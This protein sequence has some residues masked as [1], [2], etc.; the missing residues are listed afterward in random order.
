MAR[1]RNSSTLRTPFAIGNI[2]HY[3]IRHGLAIAVAATLAGISHASAQDTTPT[4]TSLLIPAAVRRAVVDRISYALSRNYVWPDTASRMADHLASQLRTGVYDGITDPQTF[5]A[6]LTRDLRAVYHDVHL[7][8][9]Y[10]PSWDDRDARNAPRTSRV[11]R[12]YGAL[13]QAKTLNFG[14]RRAEI[15]PGNIGYLAIDHLFDVG[16]AA[17]SAVESAFSVVRHGRVL[18]IDLRNNRGGSPDMVRLICNYLFPVRTHLNDLY[19]RRS[20]TTTE[21]WSEPDRHITSL[22]NV[23]V[24]VLVSRQTF[25]A[26][27]ELA[28]DL[29]S[30]HRAVIVGEATGGGAHAVWG[31]PLGYG[32]VANIPYARAINPVTKTNW[33]DIGVQPDIGV[34]VDSAL[35][36]VVKL[37]PATAVDSPRRDFPHA[38]TSRLRMPRSSIR[39]GW[40]KLR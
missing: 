27:E 34:G 18:I 23:P 16:P 6:A 37:R 40:R 8:I 35:D 1:F 26:A 30:R 21:Y 33:E 28:Y 12:R 7:S 13:S 9:A 22:F 32:F 15:L 24:F 36:L 20:G 10:A 29:Q 5:A 19:E 11:T 38:D 3:D 14:F 17:T 2:V 39:G 4:P 25:S 31:I